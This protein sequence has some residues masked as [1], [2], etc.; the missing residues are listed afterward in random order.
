[1]VNKVLL[2]TD[3]SENAT[4]AAKH[5]LEMAR[6][7]PFLKVT[8]LYVRPTVDNLVRYHP[9]VNNQVINDEISEM[10]KN[11]VK[12][13]RAM[14]EDEGLYVQSDIVFGEPGQAIAEYANDEEYGMII[15][16]TRGLSNLTGIILGSVSHQVLHFSK[17]PVLFVK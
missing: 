15:M 6:S 4:R 11:I 1:M 16:G 7:N 10:A 12:R 8:I 9:F 3:G 5:T 2:A 14:F 13:T 17:V